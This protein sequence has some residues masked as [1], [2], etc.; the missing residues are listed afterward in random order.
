MHNN[1]A[2]LKSLKFVVLWP[3][4]GLEQK[5]LTVR[6]NNIETLM[7]ET[8]LL[9]KVVIEIIKAETRKNNELPIVAP[10]WR[11]LADMS[12]LSLGSIFKFV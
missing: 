5:F 12:P 3:F 1:Y 11:D 8:T 9:D 4:K 2:C 6:H 7:I 10:S